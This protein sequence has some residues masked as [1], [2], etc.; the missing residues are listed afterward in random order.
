MLGRERRDA[1]LEAVKKSPQI[2][3]WIGVWRRDERMAQPS[4][5]QLIRD[6]RDR[7][8]VAMTK[9]ARIPILTIAEAIVEDTDRSLGEP[10]PYARRED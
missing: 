4:T 2:S 9:S 6:L 8:L 5:G 10:K 3:R 1:L 7:I